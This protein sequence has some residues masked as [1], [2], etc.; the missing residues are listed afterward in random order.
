MANN[1]STF[2]LKLKSE[3]MEQMQ[4]G[5]K[6]IRENLEGAQK[7]ASATRV[8][9]SAAA[10]PTGMA[11]ASAG[12]GGREVEEYN[13]ASGAAGKAGGSARDFAD[14][15]R[16][17][18]GL[19]RLYATFA[20]NIFAATAA[21]G[22]LSRAMDT[23]NMIQGLDQLGA[24]SGRNLGTL[25]KNLAL[26][27]DGA[28]SLRDAMEATAKASAAGLTNK[29][30]LQIGD[31]A[32]Q[33]SL[34]L[35]ISMPDALS[36]LSRGISKIEPEL[37]DELGLFVK[38]DD[39]V[40]SYARTLGKSASTLTDFER[41]QAFANAVLEQA[42][43]K[44]SNITVDVNP[45]NKLLATLQNVL[46][47][48]LEVVNKVLGPIAKLLSES[49]TALAVVLAG[50]GVTLLKQVLPVV[51]Q[52]RQG[53][54]AAADDAAETAERIKKSFGD[55]FQ[56][57][58]E[59]RFRIPG[60][61]KSLKETE[62]Q[63]AKISSQTTALGSVP[64]ARLSR[65]AAVQSTA[66]D[67]KTI[68]S[69][70][71]MVAVRQKYVDTGIK[72]SKQLSDAAISGYTTEINYLN[73]K[74][75]LLKQEAQLNALNA[76]KAKQKQQLDEAFAK[77]QII[78][79]KPP[80]K[81]DPETLAI[82]E[83]EAATKKRD[84]LSAISSAADNARI[85]GVRQSWALLNQ[86]IADK[87]I[88][89][90]SKYT[91]MAQGG[92]AAV[93]ARVI[94]LL[95]AL[96]QL[97]AAIAA[98][99]AVWELVTSVAS[100]NKK[101]AEATAAGFD[102]LNESA[103]FVDKVL[104]DISKKDPLAKISVQS[105][106][107]RATALNELTSS[108]E[109]QLDKIT[110]QVATANTFDVFIDGFKTAIGKDLLSTSAKELSFGVTQSFKL[111]NEGL[112]K[113]TAI[114]KF[115]EAFKVD[116]TDQAALDK[117]LSENP[118][119][120]KAVAPQVIALMKELGQ[121]VSNV[122]SRG[123]ELTD[124]FDSAEKTLK[125]F[126]TSSL[127]TD[128]VAKFGS[129]LIDIG[130]KLNEALKNPETRL[131][132]IADIA[133]NI[134][135]RSL[136]GKEFSTNLTENSKEILQAATNLATFNQAL[137]TTQARQR[138]LQNK[139]SKREGRTVQGLTKDEAG[140]LANLNKVIP[141]IQNLTKEPAKVINQAADQLEKAAAEAFQRGSR[142]M[143]ASI[144][145]SFA[146]A[147]IT[148]S[149]A[150]AERL[151]D[152]EAGINRRA[153]LE[154]RSNSLQINQLVAQREML[155]A[156]SS[157]TDVM[158]K[159]TEA[160]ELNTIAQKEIAKTPLTEQETRTKTSILAKREAEARGQ[161]GEASRTNK[162]LQLAVDNINAQIAQVR[163][164]NVGVEVKRQD[165]IGA[166]QIKVANDLLSVETERLATRKQLFEIETRS[167]PYLTSE[168]LASKK[169]L[170]DQI[171]QNK[172][173][174]EYS[175]IQ[176]EIDRNLRTLDPENKASEEARKDAIRGLGELGQ[177][178]NRVRQKQAEES[179][180]AE[181]SYYQSV[182]ENEQKR[183][184]FIAEQQNK[185]NQIAQET[186]NIREDA[187]SKI[188]DIELATLLQQTKNSE[189]FI[190][191]IKYE[192]EVAK[193]SEEA[194]RRESAL[195]TQYKIQQEQIFRQIVREL[196]QS[197][198][199]GTVR[200]AALALEMTA[201]EAKYN[202]EV[203]GIDRVKA[204][205]ISQAGTTKQ[206][207]L[208]TA[209]QNEELKK[210]AEILSLFDSIADAIAKAFGGKNAAAISSFVSALGEINNSQEIYNK[211]RAEQ[212]KI[213]DEVAQKEISGAALTAEDLDKQAKALKDRNNLDNKNAKD[214]I[215]NNAK[216]MGATKNLFKE[217]TV[218][219]KA[220]ASLEKALHIARIAME[221][222]ELATSLFVEKG[223]V[224]GAVAGEAGQTAATGAGFFA[225][226]GLYVTEIFSKISAQLGIFG[227]P[228]AAAIVA[229]I[230]LSAFGKKS[231]QPQGFTAEEQQKVQGSGQVLR[232]GKLVTTGAGVL[233][234]PTAK[235]KSVENAIAN[236]EKYDFKNL[237]YSN[238]MLDALR[239]IRKNTENF[240]GNLLRSIP[241]LNIKPETI[242]SGNW[243]FGKDTT[244][245]LDQGIKIIG[246]VG[247]I[248]DQSAQIFKYQNT[249]TTS[250]GFL[251]L[252]S[253][254]SY[255]PTQDRITNSALQRD[256]SLIFKDVG[257]A[258]GGAAEQLG[259]GTAESVMQAFRSVDLSE[260][261]K[262]ISLMDLK[263]DEMVQALMS[264][265]SSG[266]DMAAMQLMPSLD[267][268]RKAGESF[269]DTVMRVAND[270]RVVGLSF[271]ELGM[272]LPKLVETRARPTQAQ[273][274][275]LTT[276]QSEYN[277]ALAATKA[278]T[279]Q[280]VMYGEN[281]TEVQVTGSEAA[282]AAL[283]S[284]LIELTSAQSAVTTATNS[285]TTR[286]LD[287]VQSYIDAA[288]GLDKFVEKNRFFAENFLTEAERL[289]PVQAR[290]NAEIERLAPQLATLGITAA[291]NRDQFKQ[292]VI[293]AQRLG[294]SGVQ[295]YTDLIN[296]APAF[297]QVT[298]SVKDASLSVEDFSKKVMGNEVDIIRMQA[299]LLEKSG[300][301]EAAYTKL[302]ESVLITRQAEL[303]E[304]EKLP[305]AQK[306][307]LKYQMEYKW[308]LEDLAS[309]TENNIKINNQLISSQQNLVSYL[310]EA[311]G[312]LNQALRLR[313]EGV[314]AQGIERTIKLQDL[315]MKYYGE[316]NATR[317]RVLTGLQRYIWA[318]E[319]EE[320][321]KQTYVKALQA[322][323]QAIQR[324]VDDL[325]KTL[326]G[327]DKLLDQSAR[328]AELKNG[329]A[330]TAK[331]LSRERE[332][333]E[334]RNQ[335][336][337]DMVAIIA[338]NQEYIW[339]LEDESAI[340]DKLIEAH[341]R[342]K[343]AIEG[344]IS[345]I[346]DAI[347][348]IK[349][350]RNSLAFSSELSIMTPEQQ[351]KEARKIFEETLTAA[352]TTGVDEA[353]TKAQ[354]EAISKIPEVS[355]KFLE[356]SR[357]LFA[358]SGS[359]MTDY[360]VVQNALTMTEAALGEQLTEAQQ[361]LAELKV[362]SDALGLIEENTKTSAQLFLEYQS[363][364][365]RT[366]AAAGA[367]DSRSF[368][369][370]QGLRDNVQNQID[371]KLAQIKSIN[372]TIAGLGEKQLT[373]AEAT[374]AATK[375]GSDYQLATSNTS[376]VL[377]EISGDVNNGT[378]RQAIEA[379][380][381]ATE[382]I[383]E[384]RLANDYLN[385]IVLNTYAAYETQRQHFQNLINT[386]QE[387]S[388]GNGVTTILAAIAA[389]TAKT[390][391]NVNNVQTA[392][393][394]G[395][396][397]VVSNNTATSRETADVV[398]QAVSTTT[399][400]W[401]STTLPE[402]RGSGTVI[403]VARER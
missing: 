166:N 92:L 287:L 168:Q 381:A 205:Q 133:S 321:A 271:E 142:Y 180:R 45:Y 140:Q 402:I 65:S 329:D 248:I 149:S 288:G 293:A 126:V 218:A 235:S 179:T 300:D 261:F 145:A 18:G 379:R 255:N 376:R 295:L 131:A 51:G 221:F 120:F 178:A 392:V 67:D 13:R 146:K 16:G 333:R 141:I 105:I 324:E 78:A 132:A 143:E 345:T 374:S 189:E 242:K 340:K 272:T 246:T 403:A 289:A 95:G 21:F 117:L 183:V 208:E 195:T 234:D 187:A 316:E 7:A 310:D 203:Q 352:R 56:S 237:E 76:Q 338:A 83:Y 93:G 349:N 229:A 54:R 215:T 152:T 273:L 36:R 356:L 334:L 15:A 40:V 151:G 303:A 276:A 172:Q 362:I 174:Q 28:I 52:W 294:E 327:Y 239:G 123:K 53:L 109:D 223:K 100:A 217:K 373:V 286:N 383:S 12:I 351:Y 227:P 278:V 112:G 4:S 84:R 110:R 312:L 44:F 219:Y 116:P 77:A 341:N 79:D 331:Q 124:A 6:Q 330:A 317:L 385:T 33:A 290:V 283:A 134:G 66:A 354:Q 61:Q 251:G 137:E 177:E 23:T 233:G 298:G 252:F 190:A 250:G 169:L 68:S 262:R 357:T 47:S 108:L 387:V 138:E 213:I 249:K 118:E 147:A 1:T 368:E 384:L 347:K 348:S 395:T 232:D 240:A 231:V 390:A 220:F 353:G 277:A 192:A 94:G 103:K 224:A 394:A 214:E 34:A 222:K 358:S 326:A 71:R 388:V 236:M 306:T 27:S 102:K 62:D 328:I 228:V 243:L 364:Q 98:A 59:T 253:S 157:A 311:F 43:Q 55:E 386:P 198:G 38:I 314:D 280:T 188:R 82:N 58:L 48:G 194:K 284:A 167:Q 85:L 173:A 5:S 72:G 230:G 49:P 363:A 144:A 244:E 359:Y 211:K 367:A 99:A 302:Q 101:E 313:G 191:N 307:V 301:F 14:Q 254:T 360:Q 119:K 125:D 159:L 90:I 127:P 122:A 370:L 350:Y 135:K 282:S 107:A 380:Q 156:Q 322:Q 199:E 212:S 274:D 11:G 17:L 128:P 161:P 80:G 265:V 8:A 366:E 337:A 206:L 176:K 69:L 204:A 281:T 264:V 371:T 148:V 193:A 355:N 400:N 256:L 25:S 97:G 26:A 3:G 10:R 165:Q 346:K 263:P 397:A 160:V 391:D 260:E 31:A 150:F 268:F 241:G 19:V 162:M 184:D 270:T 305:E 114:A 57:R 336:S 64:T 372:D 320:A 104:D 115:K 129:Q 89:G 401:K 201:L 88:T 297:D 247:Q 22:A 258:L 308:S 245:V 130:T 186:A 369:E 257:K 361:Q 106:N 50:I 170:D 197:G 389:N 266:M 291:S 41:R 171:L 74:L 32:K 269:A 365:R 315:S 2:T 60:L 63:I 377:S 113:S 185:L 299:N 207:A 285:L 343:D 139:A 296:L 96:G 181:Q 86:E 325:Q 9:S 279:T 275:R 35:G 216:L 42:N 163:A 304:L 318:M 29:Q 323:A 155:T 202:A 267:K 339:A 20:A 30:I 210:Q 46:Q 309:Q 398:A 24:A 332:L 175:N 196:Q 396:T 37:L 158:T 73:K 136:L 87:G 238:Q 121:E 209:K 382:T 335:F 399:S 344:T 81:L 200:S 378:I 182:F 91:T 225:R 342:E 226:A 153:E 319:D 292:A 75:D 154:K 259:M 164:I 111:M 375:A 39:A 70:E 393:A